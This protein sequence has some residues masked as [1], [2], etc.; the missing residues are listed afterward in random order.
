[1]R[2]SEERQSLRIVHAQHLV[3]G[4]RVA[5]HR[6]LKVHRADISWDL[7]DEADPAGE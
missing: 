3:L 2:G 1:M 7:L 5:V 6:A 4:C